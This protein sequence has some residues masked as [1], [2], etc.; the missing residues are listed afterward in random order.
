MMC[1]FM[2]L[3]VCF[4][5]SRTVLSDVMILLWTIKASESMKI[6]AEKYN[7]HDLLESIKKS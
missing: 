1:V 5:S 6:I 4:K 2:S 3:F 7:C